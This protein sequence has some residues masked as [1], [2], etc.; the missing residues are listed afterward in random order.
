METPKLEPCPFCGNT[1]GVDVLGYGDEG[2][3]VRCVEC[4]AQGPQMD[5][6][7]AA[8]LAWNAAT[9]KPATDAVIVKEGE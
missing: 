9:R 1:N 6:E 4:A 5:D 8:A 7:M 2:R 3:W